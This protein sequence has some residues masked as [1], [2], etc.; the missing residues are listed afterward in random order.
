MPSTT[1]SCDGPMPSTNPARLIAAATDIARAA[2]S[3]GCAVYVCSTAVPSS[4]DD[5]ARPATAIGTNGSPS[6]AVGYQRVVNPADSASCACSMMRSIVAA[7]PPSPIL[8]P[9]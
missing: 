5:V 4:I 6:T 7:P 3:N 1:R 8:I 9:G 2:V